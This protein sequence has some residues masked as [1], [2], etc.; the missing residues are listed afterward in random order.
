MKKGISAAERYQYLYSERELAD[1]AERLQGLKASTSHVI[2]NNCYANFGV[3]NA[4][5]MKQ[6]LGGGRG[7]ATRGR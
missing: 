4:T 2:F 6:M 1:W 7:S 5:T 3:M